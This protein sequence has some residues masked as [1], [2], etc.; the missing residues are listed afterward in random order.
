MNRNAKK[1]LKNVG[2]TVVD[3]AVTNAKSG[4]CLTPEMQKMNK[5]KWCLPW[6]WKIE[7]EDKDK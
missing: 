1:V 3:N 5:E 2:K 6:T 4:G 7:D